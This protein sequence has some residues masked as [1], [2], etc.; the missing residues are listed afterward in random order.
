MQVRPFSMTGEIAM[1]LFTARQLVDA[2]ERGHLLSSQQID[3][4][5][6]DLAREPELPA[7]DPRLL[8]ERL[9]QTGQLTPFQ[10]DHLID[11]GAVPTIGPYV[12]IDVIGK[13]GMGTVYSAENP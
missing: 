10:L 12:L 6:G 13:G 5:N 11:H 3:S 9:I 8:G 7:S 4:L 2:L 1:P